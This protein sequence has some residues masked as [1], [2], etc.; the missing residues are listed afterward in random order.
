MYNPTISIVTICY[1]AANTITR[2]LQSISEQ[3]YEHIEYIIIDGASSDNTLEL[4]ARYAPQSKV[5]SQKDKGIYDAMN[6]GLHLSTG[7]YVWFVNA[8]DALFS[9]DTVR[10]IVTQLALQSEPADIIY[11]DTMLVNQEGEHL[12]LRR[13]RPPMR[14]TAESFAWGML[15]CHQAFICRRSIAPEYDLKYRYSA[16][17]DWCINAMRL[18]TNYLFIDAPIVLYLNEGTTT[19]HRWA[20]LRERFDIMS[21]HYGLIPTTLRHFCFPIRLLCQKI[22]SVIKGQ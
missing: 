18:A 13:L 16:D 22:L 21:R 5:Y 12:G 1:N 20:S 3:S 9:A 10:S 7:D 19:R 11:G 6:K 2:T 8:G 14:L 15:V 17:V 4:I